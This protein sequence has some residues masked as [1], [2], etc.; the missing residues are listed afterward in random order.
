MLDRLTKESFEAHRGEVFR[1]VAA[2]GR[3]Q[4][5]PIGPF[6]LT[7]AEVRGNGLVGRAAR[8]QF[9]VLFRGPRD[10]TLP[11][12]IYRLEN[13]AMGTLE[14]FLVPVGRDTTTTIYEAVFT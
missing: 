12:R 8:E 7:L 11:Q 14:I 9:S 5:E 4:P 1:L 13:A 2:C 3:A 6:D 10:P